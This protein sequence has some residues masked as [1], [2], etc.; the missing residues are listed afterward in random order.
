MGLATVMGGVQWTLP[1]HNRNQGNIGVAEASIRVAD[2][3]QAATAAMI[4]AEIKSAETDLAI[5]R[6]QVSAS[7]PKLLAQAEESARIALAAYREGGSDLLRL[8]DAQRVRLDLQALY[9]RT[10]AD[11]HQS[12]VALEAAMGVN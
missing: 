6:Q 12:I 1:M 7:L 10:L 11:Y 9:V 8:L 5:R 2:S 4:R 3:D